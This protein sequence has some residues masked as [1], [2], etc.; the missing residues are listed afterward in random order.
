MSV[1]IS[2]CREAP[3][4]QGTD[5]RLRDSSCRCF[6]SHRCGLIGGVANGSIDAYEAEAHWDGFSGIELTRQHICVFLSSRRGERVLHAGE[7]Y[8][9][10]NEPKTIDAG[11]HSVTGEVL[12]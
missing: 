6:G 10:P 3:N 12:S 5:P 4:A 8:L 9:E 11:T 7:S 2:K 1:T